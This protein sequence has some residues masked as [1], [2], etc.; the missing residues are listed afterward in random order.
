MADKF[1]ETDLAHPLYVYL[2]SQGYRVRSEVKDCDIAAVRGDEL[3]VIEIKKTLNLTLISQAAKRQ[4]I[5]DKVYMA[6]PRP[7]STWKWHVENR[8]VKHVVRRLEL[9]LIFV[10]LEKDKPAVD[11]V[12]HPAPFLRRKKPAHKRAVLEEIESRT[13]DFNTAGST[14]TKLMTAYRENAVRIA[15]CLKAAGPLTAKALRELG[16]GPKTY[17]VLYTNV[18]GWFERAGAARYTLSAHGETDMA[19][20]PALVKKYL[21]QARRALKKK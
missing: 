14:R 19:L 12:L 5:T 13:A 20:Y 18:Y 4:R 8:A 11:V 21:A 9:G 7:A 10:S 2:V 1:S 3:L 15:C 6:I 17:S 16:N